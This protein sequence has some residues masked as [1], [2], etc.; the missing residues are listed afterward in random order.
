[1]LLITRLTEAGLYNLV[2]DK[3]FSDPQQLFYRDMFE[4]YPKEFWRDVR[5]IIPKLRH[6]TLNEDG[7]NAKS[8]VSA[9]PKY[10]AVHSF[11]ELLQAKD[12]L[13]VNFTQNID[14]LELDAGVSPDKLVACHGTWETATCLTCDG[15]VGARDYLPFVL[16]GKLPLCSCGKPT[17]VDPNAR[18]S[19]RLKKAPKIEEEDIAY[20]DTIGGES[21]GSNRPGRRKR[22]RIESELDSI[23]A[24]DS[25]DDDKF[26]APSRPG[27]LKPNIT[28]FGESVAASYSPTLDDIKED[29]DLLIIVGTSLAAAPVSQLPLELPRDVPQIWI[30]NERCTNKVKGLQVDIELIGDADTIIHEICARAG[31]TNALGNRLWRNNLGSR[32]QGKAIQAR[33]S[34]AKSQ[35][36][37]AIQTGAVDVDN[38]ANANPVTATKAALP[39]AGNLA[40]L[41]PPLSNE[42][43]EVPTGT[44]TTTSAP[45]TANTS[46]QSV[47][48]VK[49]PLPISVAPPIFKVEEAPLS[50][51]IPIRTNSKRPL[52]AA[53]ILFANETIFE[54]NKTGDS[55]HGPILKKLRAESPDSVKSG[56]PRSK[57]PAAG[58][59]TS[60]SGSGRGMA[61][62]SVRIFQDVAFD[63]VTYFRR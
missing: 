7:S 53:E 21:P 37:A 34:K 6:G 8:L 58:K 24:R 3:R 42:T 60:G 46:P 22:R 28:F 44:S 5:P 4:Q 63:W 27:L 32:A 43:P 51:P 16:A 26:D 20:V 12:R 62:A 17:P 57:P 35:Q 47:K 41:Q 10:S 55:P 11:L 23:L 50:P 2:Q 38:N 9:V 40:H 15:K 61:D 56:M 54:G 33:I 1:M 39:R 25:D 31:W 59:L 14:A 13:L 30:S 45:S 18:Q 29:A 52:S 48:E 49:Q 19:T 36:A